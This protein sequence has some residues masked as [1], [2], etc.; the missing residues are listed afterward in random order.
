MPGA[1]A[2]V[3]DDAGHHDLMHGEDHRGRSAGAAERVADIDDVGDAGA[4][5]AEI[6]RHH[7]AQQPL[8]A[9]GGEGFGRKARI[10]IDGVGMLGRDRRN[11]L[12]AEG[13]AL[14]SLRR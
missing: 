6:A 11:L 12:G 10:A 4:F 1:A 9:R 8:G 5:A 7:D 2:A 3:A 14:G 13:E